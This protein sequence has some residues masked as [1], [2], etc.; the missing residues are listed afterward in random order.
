MELFIVHD[1]G[2]REHYMSESLIQRLR[3][4]PKGA[5]INDPAAQT[6]ASWWH[7]PGEPLSTVLS[8][9]GRVD[10]RMT[11]ETFA[12]EAEYQRADA[13]DKAAL[14][15]LA[16]YLAHHIGNA[17][18]GYRPCACRDCFDTAI[19]IVGA[20]CLECQEHGCDYQ[21]DC[22][23]PDA[24]GAEEAPCEDSDDCTCIYCIPGA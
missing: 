15:A 4:M 16:A 17:P 9:S 14:D 20:M 24:Y 18:S 3:E 7:S 2:R 23:R 8:T 11:R 19:G 10:A 12:S 6:I 13:D 21:S 1:G 5:I 22:E